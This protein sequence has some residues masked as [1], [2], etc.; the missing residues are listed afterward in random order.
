MQNDYKSFGKV[1]AVEI[2]TKFIDINQILH[3]LEQTTDQKSMNTDVNELTIYFLFPLNFS[4]SVHIHVQSD[5][6]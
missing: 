2:L 5:L 4:D 6:C 1:I 3:S